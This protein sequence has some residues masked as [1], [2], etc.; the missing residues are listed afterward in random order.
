MLIQSLMRNPKPIGVVGLGLMGSAL[1]ERLSGAG[2]AV[3]GFDVDAAKCEALE[4]AGSAV[5]ASLPEVAQGCDFIFVAVFDTDQ[6]EAVTE[7]ELLPAIGGNSGKTILCIS[8]CDPDR[9]AALAARTEPRG[10]HFLEAPV[11]G[12]SE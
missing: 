4:Q 8:T 6:V 3:L 5:A 9:I 12:T 1:A 7:K 2:P 11:S 10:L